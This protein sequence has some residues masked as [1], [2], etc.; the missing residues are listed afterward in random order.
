MP[1]GCDKRQARIACGCRCFAAIIAAMLC[2]VGV[3]AIPASA[4]AEIREAAVSD[5]PDGMPTISGA[6]D[7]PDISAVTARYDSAG[8]LSL[9]IDFYRSVNELDTSENY[10]FFGEFMVGGAATFGYSATEV[11]HCGGELYGQ[12]HVFASTGLQFYD[13]ATITGYSGTLKF[14]RATSPDGRQI[15]LSASSPALANHDWR[16]FGYSLS[17][18]THASA[19]NIY[20]KYDGSCDC[21]YVSPTLDI[22]GT[23]ETVGAGPDLWFNGF[24]P[25]PVPPEET[26]AEKRKH[27]KE[28]EARE[29]EEGLTGSQAVKYMTIALRRRLRK[30]FSKGFP[31][32]VSCG[33]ESSRLARR[34]WISWVSAPYSHRRT[35]RG[36]GHVWLKR[37]RAG[38]VTWNYSWKLRRVDRLCTKRHSVRRCTRVFVARHRR[39]GSSTG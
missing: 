15:T 14:S 19:A 33:E 31:Q 4:G 37:N 25:V 39:G 9:V 17:S 13:Q 38:A 28:Q 30:A 12:N 36:W 2:G 22:L 34:C 20:S 16:C 10:A 27:Q 8:S 24:A 21:W 26:A 11:P 6:P 23:T 29:D 18:R 5:P 7:N 3:V 32:T 1:G 35:W